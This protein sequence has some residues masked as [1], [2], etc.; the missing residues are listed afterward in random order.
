MN[1]LLKHA[2]IEY[3]SN[4]VESCG[5]DQKNMFKTTKNLL[6]GTN[7]VILPTNKSSKKLSQDFSDFFI[8][9]IED[10]RTGISSQSQSASESV[11]IVPEPSAVNCV[12][13]FTPVSQEEVKRIIQMSPNKSCVI[14]PMPTWLLKLYLDELLPIFT[15]IINMSLES[16]YVPHSFKN[17]RIIPLLKKPGL[18]Q[19]LCEE[20]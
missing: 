2:R 6:G 4:K 3:Y 12:D 19:N 5:H 15:K 20:L 17:A 14:D 18:D 16:P 8:D 7:E 9:K 10:I 11:N 13:T 1:R